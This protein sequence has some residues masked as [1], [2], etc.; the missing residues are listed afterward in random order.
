MGFAFISACL[1]RKLGQT[2]LAANDKVACKGSREQEGREWK[3]VGYC[4]GN[5]CRALFLIVCLCV[6]LLHA[7]ELP[8]TSVDEGLLPPRRFSGDKLPDGAQRVTHWE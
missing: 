1:I 7:G 3:S 5:S 8:H 4:P 2:G 6:R